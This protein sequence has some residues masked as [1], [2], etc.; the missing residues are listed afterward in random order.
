MIFSD[1]FVFYTFYSNQQTDLKAKHNYI[2]FYFVYILA[3]PATF[4]GF[5]QCSGNRLFIRL[6]M[7]L[8]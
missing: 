8:D 7:S 1:R 4:S 2:L 5:K 3:D 6:W